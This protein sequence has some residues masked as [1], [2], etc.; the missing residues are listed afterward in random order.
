MTVKKKKGNSKNIFTVRDCAL[1]AVAT[2]R[3]ALNL[4]E[5]AAHIREV[6]LASIHY[7]FWGNRLRPRFDPPDYQNDFA[8]WAHYN[9]HDDVISERLA[10]INPTEFESTERLQEKVL[11][12]IEERLAEIGHTYWQTAD[13]DFAFIRSQIVVFDTGLRARSPEELRDLLPKLS[14]SA[15]FYHFID[16]RLR[17][18]SN[19]DDFRTWLVNFG[20]G[21]HELVN[22]L[23]N[24]DPYFM[25]LT[26]LR[27]KLVGLFQTY[28][29]GEK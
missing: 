16:G 26:E 22:G 9:L 1:L 18:P 3:N 2:G 24:L 23:A 19:V 6:E 12:V 7:H 29:E 17:L 10:I 14:A 27:D 21:Y 25:T 11:D 28:C 5:L 15:V 8:S 20:D 13:Q 4:R